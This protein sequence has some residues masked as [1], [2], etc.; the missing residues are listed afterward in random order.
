[1][2]D[3]VGVFDVLHDGAGVSEIDGRVLEACLGRVGLVDLDLFGQIF[4]SKI[5]EV[6]APEALCVTEEVSEERG[7]SA[8]T[9]L[10]EGVLR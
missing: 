2:E 9:D 4:G 6:D 7:R 1:L 5:D 10:K 3:G 8:A